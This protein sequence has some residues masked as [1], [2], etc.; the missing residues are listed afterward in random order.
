MMRADNIV[1]Y[2]AQDKIPNSSDTFHLSLYTQLLFDLVNYATSFGD[3]LTVKT[4]Q[5]NI[6]P[7]EVKIESISDSSEESIELK[8]FLRNKI[9]QI[10]RVL[11]KKITDMEKELI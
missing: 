8:K 2:L 11:D 3:I 9:I 10:N 5:L 4:I 1:Q 6:P 7:I